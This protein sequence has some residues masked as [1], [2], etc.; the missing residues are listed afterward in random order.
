MADTIIRTSETRTP[1]A[2]S[3]AAPATIRTYHL[4]RSTTNADSGAH[5][6]ITGDAQL[7]T[8][9]QTAAGNTASDELRTLIRHVAGL[10]GTLRV[11][12]G[13][14]DSLLRDLAADDTLPITR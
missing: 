2:G 10:H 4:V 11:P 6:S 3:G 7:L 1:I 13:T 8:A 12:R 14:R 9:G 5:I